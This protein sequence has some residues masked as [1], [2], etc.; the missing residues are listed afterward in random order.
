MWTPEARCSS[1]DPP[2][3]RRMR[4]EST[5]TRRRRKACR[6]EVCERDSSSLCVVAT[7]AFEASHLIRSPLLSFR[8]GF[9]E[10]ESRRLNFQSRQ[11]RRESDRLVH[12]H[13]NHPA[14]RPPQ[15]RARRVA[16]RV[17]CR[18]S[19]R[20]ERHAASAQRTSSRAAHEPP[21]PASRPCRVARARRR[22]AARRLFRWLTMTMLRF[23]I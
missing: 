13:T 16:V 23:T 6:S 20:A 19:R 7:A 14:P 11:T 2:C 18:C 5:A 3:R 21:V 4:H 9:A 17:R 22:T 12:P 1:L 10:R 15:R 8:L